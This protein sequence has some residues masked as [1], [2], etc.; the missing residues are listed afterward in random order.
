[1]KLRYIKFISLFSIAMLAIVGC[2][3]KELVYEPSEV[4]ET[5]DA[6]NFKVAI[7]QGAVTTQTCALTFTPTD[8]TTAYVTLV[9][10]RAAANMTVSDKT[11]DLMVE[12]LKKQA[13]AKGLTYE[14]YLGEIQTMGDKTITVEGLQ[15]NTSYTV[16]SFKKVGDK[17][18]R[19]PANDQFFFVTLLADKL[20][21]TFDV[22]KTVDA[23]SASF[24]VTPSIKDAKYYFCAFTKE[25]YDALKQRGFSNND[26]IVEHLKATIPNKMLGEQ[27]SENEAFDQ[28]T[29]I[30]HHTLTIQQLQAKTQYVYL[31]GAI[32]HPKSNVFYL[33]SDVTMGNFTSG[34][35]VLKKVNFNMEISN[36]TDQ[37]FDIK[38]DPDDKDIVYIW[39]YQAFDSKTENMTPEEIAANIMKGPIG[40]WDRNKGLKSYQN[41]P[42][43]AGNKYYVVAFA[44]SGKNVISNVEMKRFETGGTPDAS[45]MTFNVDVNKVSPYSSFLTFRPSDNRVYYA[46]ALIED[47]KISLQ[48]LRDGFAK[49][50]ENGYK[51]FV[52]VN[53]GLTKQDFVSSYYFHGVHPHIFGELKP[54]KKYTLFTFNLT[55]EATIAHAEEKVSF[56]TTPALSDAL[57]TPKVY[58]VFDG[59]ELDPTLITNYEIAKDLAVVV[60]E[61]D[62]KNAIKGFASMVPES[63]DKVE[64]DP[65]LI[66]DDMVLERLK[67]DFVP[68]TTKQPYAYFVCEWDRRQ[69]SLSYGKNDKDIEGVVMRNAIVTPTMA[70]KD[71]ISKLRDLVKKLEANDNKNQPTYAFNVAS[72][73]NVG[74]KSTGDKY[75][76]VRKPDFG[77]LF[78]PKG[79]RRATDMQDKNHK[80]SKFSPELILPLI[81][82]Y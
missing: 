71:D 67:D 22:K 76:V 64:L 50:L 77:D 66:P 55:N 41:L 56:I 74:N 49:D 19:Q 48:K 6:S 39:R 78:I 1:M 44:F 40:P 60:L 45:T 21:I 47:G 3:K 73:A 15:A 38:I 27:L 9:L 35:V 29:F 68:L 33:R 11:Y 10:P 62:M 59:N 5:T 28:L 18:D 52:K 24:A 8:K 81:P 57:V 34:E 37:K 53:Q 25:Q 51:Q 20:N 14:Q 30:G 12:E 46:M 75:M 82:V 72:L 4:T 17:L 31:I 63:F 2:K 43:Q 58:G 70:K 23:L 7:A 79:M 42:V 13:S 32:I 69:V 36:Q 61:Y 16:V 54:N 80:Q 26:M 65:K